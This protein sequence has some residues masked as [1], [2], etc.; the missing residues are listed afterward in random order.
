MKHLRTFIKE[1]TS[2]ESQLKDLYNQYGYDWSLAPEIMKDDINHHS[3][4]QQRRAYSVYHYLLKKELDS[5]KNI[6]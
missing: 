2:M 5:Y 3:Y 4:N 6:V 1:C